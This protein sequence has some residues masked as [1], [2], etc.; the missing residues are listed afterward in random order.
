MGE[1]A[2]STVD[3]VGRDGKHCGFSGAQADAAKYIAYNWLTIGPDAL[4]KK[5][6]KE[7]PDSP[8]Q[9]QASKSWPRI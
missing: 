7:S 8:R 1:W 4:I 9:I 5:Y 6:K 2:D 3:R